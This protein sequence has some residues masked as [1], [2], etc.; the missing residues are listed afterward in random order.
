[1][2]AAVELWDAAQ[3]RLI[4]EQIA[5][6]ATDD[7]LRL[8]AQVCAK[9]GLDPFSR[10]IY[11]IH[12]EVSE[13]QDGGQWVKKQRMTIQTSIDGFR[14]I[15]ERSGQYEGQTP[16]EWCGPDGKWV[17]VWLSANQPA[18]ARVGVW[19]TGFREPLYGIATWKEYAQ[20]NGPMWKKMGPH[21]LAKCAESLALRA[22]FPADLSGLYTTDEFPTVEQ[23]DRGA[24]DRVATPTRTTDG[25]PAVT[26]RSEGHTDTRPALAAAAADN[27]NVDPATGDITP[28]P[29]EVK[30]RQTA[31]APP[32]APKG[33]QPFTADDATLASPV[34]VREL[35]KDY[36]ALM[37]E[38]K[39][40]VT[41][42]LPA[43]TRSAVSK[44]DFAVLRRQVD[45][46]RVTQVEV[47]S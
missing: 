40:L 43:S 8:F 5:P 24:G 29:V 14:V 9:T 35:L 4:K 26:P 11:A 38:Q 34:D 12:R 3:K 37:S 18:A 39:K 1:M 17:T 36:G 10:Q 15:A 13:K 45:E 41:H 27:S 2:T 31:F 7:E 20:E 16:K 32:G 44:D 46:A 23:Q 33:E 19:R 21:M 47:A 42:P 25:T 22:A 6:K 28:E 30:S